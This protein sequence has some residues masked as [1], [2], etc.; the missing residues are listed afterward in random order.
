MTISEMFSEFINNLAIQNRDEISY[1]YGEIT[2]ALNQKYRNSESKT[3]NSL[4][5]G[6]YGR[7]TATNGISD[8]DMIYIM[9]SSEWNRF[10][11]GRQSALLQEVK[12]AI[13]KRYPKTEMRGDGQVVVVSFSNNVIEVLP[14]FEQ[15][16]GN[17]KYPDTHNGGS[18]RITKPREE[19]TE[20]K[21]FDEKKNRNYRRLCKMIR[22]WK[23]KHGI[24]MGGLLID[25]LVYNFLNNT[26]EYDDKSFLYYDWMIRDFFKYISEE[27][28]KSYYYAPGSNQKVYVKKKFQKK[29]KK[30][31][32]LSL[33]AIEAGE[34]KS[35]H[36]KWKKIFGRPFPSAP[37]VAM[38]SAARTWKNT[39]EYIE[40][41]YP[42]DIQYELSIDCE[43]TQDGFRPRFLREMLQKRMLLKPNKKLLFS[44]KKNNV[45]EPYS[46][47]W[48]VLNRG[49]EAQRRDEIRGQI[50][51]D[52]GYFTKEERTKF[53]GD[54]IVECYIIKDN[55]VLAR[56]E[57]E[58]PIE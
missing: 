24:V 3:S 9:P 54:H 52:N 50:V 16:D 57:I 1:R 43:V 48:K 5:V 17:F 35:A 44:I 56:D 2:K 21:A 30:A 36:T 10:K 47:K 19:I 37:I 8:L 51:D 7:H 46:V 23:N 45:P 53:K 49:E 26:T 4:Q 6:S 40:D 22:A 31:Y 32:N 25:T 38:E 34:Q 29:T 14:A 41:F 42:V 13:K 55:K 15:D 18:W 58:V 12:Q 20:V 39:E 28:D 27:N 33:E 11:D